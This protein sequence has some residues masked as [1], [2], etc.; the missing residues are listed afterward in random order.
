MGINCRYPR[1]MKILK[2]S[3]PLDKLLDTRLLSIYYTPILVVN[4]KGLTKI[5]IC[6]STKKSLSKTR[7]KHVHGFPRMTM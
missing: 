1:F 7:N 2:N 6:I 3:L 4:T 5:V